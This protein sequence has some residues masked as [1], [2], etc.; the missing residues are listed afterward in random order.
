MKRIVTSAAVGTLMFIA[1]A[2]VMAESSTNGA[3]LDGFSQQPAKV[4]S[5]LAANGVRLN[6]ISLNGL[7]QRPPKIV[8]RLA[9]NGTSINGIKPNDLSLNDLAAHGLAKKNADN[10]F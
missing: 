4:V 6:G 2:Q 10:R 3:G 7:S 9:A 5:R 1:A 8:S